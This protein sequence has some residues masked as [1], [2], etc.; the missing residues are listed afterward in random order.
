MAA[1]GIDVP[2]VTYKTFVVLCTFLIVALFS[3]L[4]KYLTLWIFHNK[5]NQKRVR[6]G[7]PR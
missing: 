6:K 5:L 2:D 4:K 7:K 1:V 3:V